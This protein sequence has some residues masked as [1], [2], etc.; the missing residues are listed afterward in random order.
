MRLALLAVSK[1]VKMFFKVCRMGR[2]Y[3][4]PLSLPSYQAPSTSLAVGCDGAA[5]HL[6]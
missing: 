6:V 2:A 3:F 4:A 1:A 5:L